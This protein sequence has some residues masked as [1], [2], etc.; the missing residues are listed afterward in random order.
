MSQVPKGSGLE[1]LAR[2]SRREW[3]LLAGLALS[4]VCLGLAVRGTSPQALWQ[5]LATAQWQWIG[6]AIVLVLA[7]TA[8]KTLRWQVLFFPQRVPLARLWSIFCIGQMLNTLLPARAG[9]VGRLYYVGEVEGTSRSQALSTI[10]VEKMVDL[11]MLALAYLLVAAWLATTSIVLPDWLHAAGTVVLPLAGL[12][13]GGLLVLAYFGRP[14]WQSV[15]RVLAPLPPAWRERVE[16][17]VER[18]MVGF[19]ALRHPPTSLRV[20]LWSLL[21]W[22]FSVATNVLVFRAFEID[23]GWSAA[24]L[25]VVVLMSGVAVPPLPGNLG[26]FPYL[27]QLTLSLFGV[28]A[29]TGLVYG[30]VLQA[31]AYLPLVVLGLVLLLRENWTLRRASSASGPPG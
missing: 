30:L 21:A 5:A 13:L 2:W 20:W 1:R 3:R 6:P 22:I 12:A 28:P 24:L 9:E 18:A 31:V 14:A 4:V 7:G 8:F 17:A 10:V 25:L 11:I 23:L 19:E 15:R 27:C 26:V 16:A 29:E